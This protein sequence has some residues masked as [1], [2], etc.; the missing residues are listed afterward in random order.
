MTKLSEC[1]NEVDPFFSDWQE[2]DGK[3][4]ATCTK[5]PCPIV[6]PFTGVLPRGGGRVIR[7]PRILFEE[8]S[9]YLGDV[10]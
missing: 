8:M 9:D 6:A 4:Y 1:R 3:I 10:D 7:S 5:L 2:I